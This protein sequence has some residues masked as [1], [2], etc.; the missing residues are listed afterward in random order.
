M[1]VHLQRL[2]L[3]VIYVLVLVLLT[4]FIF[5]WRRS[6]KLEQE[7]QRLEQIILEQTREM[8]EMKKQLEK[9]TVRFLADFS[10][11]F[12]TPLTLI[13]LPLEHLLENCRDKEMKEG[14][15][16][17]MENSLQ[18]LT[19]INRLPHIF[20]RFLREGGEAKENP[21]P[22]TNDSVRGQN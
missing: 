13:M 16:L 18:L 2:F 11:E 9:Q 17:M 12:R 21:Q 3:P 1:T 10:H 8:E 6:V 22:K 20:Q 4:Y 14:L 7:K 19:L 5:L 15:N